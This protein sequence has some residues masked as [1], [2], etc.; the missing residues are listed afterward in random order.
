MADNRSWM[1]IGVIVLDIT[2]EQGN[3]IIVRKS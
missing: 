1:D 2:L 3:A